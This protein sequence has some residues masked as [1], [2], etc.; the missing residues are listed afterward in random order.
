M[1]KRWIS[2][3]ESNKDRRFIRGSFR[4][5]YE[6]LTEA[7]LDLPDELPCDLTIEIKEK[8]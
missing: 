4:N 3:D 8:K 1:W 5:P 2:T 6:T 7:M